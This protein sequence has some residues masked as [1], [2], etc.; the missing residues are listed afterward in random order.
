MLTNVII[1]PAEHLHSRACLATAIISAVENARDAEHFTEHEFRLHAQDNG[2]LSDADEYLT[3]G[4]ATCT[5]PPCFRHCCDAVEGRHVVACGHCGE[6]DYDCVCPEEEP[7]A[8]A[9]MR[10]ALARDTAR[11]AITKVEHVSGSM[12]HEQKDC[13]QDESCPVWKGWNK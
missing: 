10:D 1:R 13:P 6:P 3:S 2:F 8:P 4:T 9:A 7:I 11:Y 5:C 12:K